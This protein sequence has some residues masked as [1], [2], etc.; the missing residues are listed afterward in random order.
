[1]ARWEMV[2]LRMDN[3]EMPSEWYEPVE[4]DGI[5]N[6]WEKWEE[7]SVED[8]ELRTVIERVELRESLQMLDGREWEI[9]WRRFWLEETFETIGK[10]LG[11]SRERIRQLESEAMWKLRV[12][13]GAN[14]PQ[15]G[16]R[17]AACH[18]HWRAQH[19]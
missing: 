4:V 17:I 14:L 13:L 19:R 11:L 5:F 15:V 10:H 3:G 1:M 6:A 2:R 12:A 16:N 8:K 7:F 9:I 18:A